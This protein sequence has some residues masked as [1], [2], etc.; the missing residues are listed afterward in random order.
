MVLDHIYVL[1]LGTYKTLEI[2]WLEGNWLSDT[3]YGFY[4]DPDNGYGYFN[5]PGSS[6][7]VIIL[8]SGTTWYA[9][10]YSGSTWVVSWSLN[11]G[12]SQYDMALNGGEVYTDYA[13]HPTFPVAYTDVAKLYLNGWTNWDWQRW[14]TTQYINDADA[15]SLHSITNYYNFYVQSD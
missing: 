12:Y 14:A 6:L 10:Y 2:G 4:Y 5:L 11:L 3:Q 13:T 7:E 9:Q 1:N 15:Y 8:H